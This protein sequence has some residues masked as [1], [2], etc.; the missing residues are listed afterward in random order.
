METPGIGHGRNVVENFLQDTHFG[1]TSPRPYTPIGG[2]PPIGG[3][4]QHAYGG[5][6]PP[7]GVRWGV[8]PSSSVVSSCGAV[9]AVLPVIPEI[10]C[11]T[12][13]FGRPSPR[14]Y[15]PI[16]GS[17]LIGG[18]AQHASGGGGTAP[19]GGVGFGAE[20]KCRVLIDSSPRMWAIF[21]ELVM[22][23]RSKIKA[24]LVLIFYLLF[25]ISASK[26]A[27]IRGLPRMLT[28]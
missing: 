6:E 5:G 27:V 16:G 26:L 24:K 1:H 11:R 12:P 15:T 18:D 20:F 21:D 25:I 17:P 8:G 13:I 14:P 4:A 9:S 23:S 2:S 19:W 10:S 3:D 7:H 22:K 28:H